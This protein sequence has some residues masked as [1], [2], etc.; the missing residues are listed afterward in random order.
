MLEEIRVDDG[1]IALPP[2]A[3][4]CAILAV[5]EG[6]GRLL[7]GSAAGL[8][9]DSYSVLFFPAGCPRREIRASEPFWA[10]WATPPALTPAR[11]GQ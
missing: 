6:R 8:P 4:R 10:L 9:L 11:E 2:T 3:G 1:P 7:D 5:L